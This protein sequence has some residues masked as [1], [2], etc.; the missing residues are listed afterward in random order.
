MP[1]V[2]PRA[3]VV[4]SPRE[5]AALERIAKK[6]DRSVSWLVREGC[7]RINRQHREKG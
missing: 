7:R 2:N 3:S 6:Q 1:P 4:L 5:K